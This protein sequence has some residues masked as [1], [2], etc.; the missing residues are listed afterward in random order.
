LAHYHGAEH[1]A[2][3]KAYSGYRAVPRHIVR[4]SIQLTPNLLPTF[5]ITPLHIFIT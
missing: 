2:Q 5:S 3:R 1:E 4:L